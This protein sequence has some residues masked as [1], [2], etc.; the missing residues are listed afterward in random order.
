MQRATDNHTDPLETH[1]ALNSC[2]HTLLISF[3]AN[4]FFQGFLAIVKAVVDLGFYF[5][6]IAQFNCMP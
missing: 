6:N 2:R 3:Q 5:L 4:S 1:T